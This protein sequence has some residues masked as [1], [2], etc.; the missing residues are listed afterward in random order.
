MN[1]FDITFDVSTTS[2]AAGPVWVP[3][4]VVS[5]QAQSVS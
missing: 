5:E 2:T 1:K 4:T 3:G